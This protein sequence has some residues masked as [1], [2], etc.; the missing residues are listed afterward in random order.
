MDVK[1]SF[2][3]GLIYEEVYVKQ[4]PGFKD[5]IHPDYVI[6]LK[7]SLYGLKQ[8]PR[9]W[10]ERLRNFLLENGFQKGQ[11]DINTLKNNIL[12]L[13]VYVDNSIFGSTNS[14]LCQEFSK[15]M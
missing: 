1:S 9:V 14:F 4:P 15:T 6:K 12:I 10:Y 13:Q 8:A 11:V 3:N 7:K 2:L 5:P